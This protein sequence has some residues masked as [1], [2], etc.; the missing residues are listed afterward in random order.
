MH[1]AC[2]GTLL[3]FLAYDALCCI[4]L[5]TPGGLSGANFRAML[6]LLSV[7]VSAGVGTI[8][9]GAIW[10]KCTRPARTA[11]CVAVAGFAFIGYFLYFPGP[12]SGLTV[13]PGLW[14]S[15]VSSGLLAAGGLFEA[16]S[17]WE[18]TP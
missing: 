13:Y 11:A 5:I 3:A 14:V 16:V 8:L 17:L 9:V 4:P 1:A 18:P 12:D 15:L 7:I 10:A 2:A 6:S